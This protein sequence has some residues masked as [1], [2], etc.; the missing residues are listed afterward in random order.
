MSTSAAML[1]SVIFLILDLHQTAH[2]EVLT[3]THTKI[4]YK[5]YYLYFCQEQKTVD[6]RYAT[7]NLMYHE[8]R[9]N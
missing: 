1:Y 6:M 2:H 9:I 5:K 8:Y 7:F 4:T 3:H